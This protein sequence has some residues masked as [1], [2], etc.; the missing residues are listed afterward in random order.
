MHLMS[1][2]LS[3]A[4]QDAHS[5]LQ[6]LTIAGVAVAL[7]HLPLPLAGRI[8]AHAACPSLGLVLPEQWK[9]EGLRTG[10]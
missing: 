1:H 2:G 7:A 3:E 4:V 8:Q 5:T 6:I 10:E 9:M